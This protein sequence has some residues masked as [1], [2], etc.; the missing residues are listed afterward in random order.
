[1]SWTKTIERYIREGRPVSGSKGDSV[2][3]SSEANSAAFQK[4]LT[5]TFKTQFANQ[6]DI[7]N[8]LNGVFSNVIS[9][10][11]GFSA[12]LLAA[13]NTNNAETVGKDYAH[14]KQAY[15]ETVAARNGGRGDSGLPSGVDEQIQAQIGSSAAQEEAS[16][17]RQIAIANEQQRQQNWWQALT[18]E[19]G[20]A[21]AENP[22]GYSQT[23]NQSADAT[24][25][26]GN[27][28]NQSKGPG[29]W[30]VLGGIAG[31]AGTAAAGYFGGKH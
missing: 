21:Q 15:A 19:E 11:A 9:N 24:A 2:L 5:D 25:N 27:A 8:K 22:L 16:G 23:A 4:T 20:V 6:T 12:P 28:F 13:L 26:I 30:S 29:F 7:L 17:T 31:G 10:P 3:Q 14:A 1:M 18:G